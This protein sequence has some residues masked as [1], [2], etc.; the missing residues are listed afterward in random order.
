MAV[1]WEILKERSGLINHL[2]YLHASAESPQ[3]FILMAG[4]EFS[5][6]WQESWV[7]KEHPCI[8]EEK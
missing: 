3:C 5:N 6:K 2:N 7:R 8:R 4:C 1:K